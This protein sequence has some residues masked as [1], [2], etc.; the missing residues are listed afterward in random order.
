[1][2][3]ILDFAL[4]A[5]T[6][7]RKAGRPSRDPAYQNWE[8]IGNRK[9]DVK[10][11]YHAQVYRHKETQEIV[12]AIRGTDFT[13]RKN[14]AK[15]IRADIELA[16]HQVTERSAVAIQHALEVYRQFPNATIS[17]TG[18]SL[19]G[20]CAQE[21]AAHF[22]N[23]PRLP[24][25]NAVTFNSPGVAGDSIKNGAD[26]PVLNLYTR[27]DLARYLGATHV[28]ALS[29]LQMGPQNPIDLFVA[30]NLSDLADLA[31]PITNVVL[32]GIN[33][34]SPKMTYILKTAGSTIGPFI[35]KGL[36]IAA[37]TISG[38]IAA[39][40]AVVNAHFMGHI[41]TGLRGS[42]AL[43]NLHPEAYRALMKEPERMQ[44]IANITSPEYGELLP[45]ERKRI[46]TLSWPA[47]L[48][49]AESRKKH[50]YRES[51]H[52]QKNR[53]W[54]PQYQHQST[55]KTRKDKEGYLPVMDCI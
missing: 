3:S 13:N 40:A 46:A 38:T 39:G 10:T 17:V 33:L 53:L 43:G 35:N 27:S 5:K 37:P 30:P 4:L 49:K 2:P 12:I 36:E 14:F 20:N 34:V 15:D 44:E 45:D 8:T 9:H 6:V 16:R 11:G 23:D 54:S 28:G 51:Q 52:H 42:P 32:K 26:Y 50:R 18:H 41:V 29:S 24:N 21:I 47:S 19:G 22:K 1:M 55:I 31:S 25:L 7:Y 48:S